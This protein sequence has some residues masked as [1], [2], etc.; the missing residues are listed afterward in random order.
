MYAIDTSRKEGWILNWSLLETKIIMV[1]V[2]VPGPFSKPYVVKAVPYV[3]RNDHRD[4]FEKSRF[5]RRNGIPDPWFDY[6]TWMEIDGEEIDEDYVRFTDFVWNEKG[7]PM[8][9]GI[10]D[11]WK[12]GNKH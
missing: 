5:K 4:Y 6:L 12:I 2:V 7:L 3:L 10:P 11:P 8:L 1:N 9:Q